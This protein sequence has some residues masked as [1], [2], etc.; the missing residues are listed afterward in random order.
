MKFPNPIENLIRR[1]RRQPGD[2]VTL[3]TRLTSEI[4]RLKEDKKT[5]EEEIVRASFENLF[6]EASSP[7]SQLLLQLHLSR[8]QSSALRPADIL[9]HVK[10]LVATFQQHGLSILGQPDEIQC[11][12]PNQ[13]EPIN[14]AFQPEPNMPV[15]I[16]FPGIAYKDSVVRRAAVDSVET[17]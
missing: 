12:D 1:F 3:V 5:S 4:K 2:Q 13:H 17:K 16:R 7:L 11:F 9:V 15:R 6:T 8:N 10:R 14:P